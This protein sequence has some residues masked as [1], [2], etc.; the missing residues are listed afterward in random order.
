[1]PDGAPKPLGSFG[2][3]PAAFLAEVDDVGP[4]DGGDV[5]RD[6]SG[7][8]GIVRTAGLFRPRKRPAEDDMS[9]SPRALG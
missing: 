3:R 7:H 1:M 6:L 4:D 2:L 9:M 8:A 5:L